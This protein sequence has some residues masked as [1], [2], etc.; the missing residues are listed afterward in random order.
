MHELS[1]A[2][3][4]HRVAR[5]E[6][7]AREG[8]RLESIRIEVGELAGVE[9]ALLEHAWETLVVGGPDEG[10]PLTVDWIAAVQ[11]CPACGP[12]AER[13]PGTWLRVCPTC[14]AALYVS[15]GRELDIVELVFEEL[16]G[17][18]R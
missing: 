15:G 17:T 10:A 12:V 1:I 14:G 18:P 9:P 8:G 5:A 2:I 3:A 6:V 7:K 13:Q 11:T 4:L 16:A